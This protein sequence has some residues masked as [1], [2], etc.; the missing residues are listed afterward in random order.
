MSVSLEQWRASFSNWTFSQPLLL[1]SQRRGWQPSQRQQGLLYAPCNVTS[2]T[3]HPLP[4]PRQQTTQTWDRKEF[5]Q[6]HEVSKEESQS[7]A[8][9]TTV[10]VRAFW[11][12][13]LSCFSSQEKPVSMNTFKT[14]LVRQGRSHRVWFKHGGTIRGSIDAELEEIL[15][16]WVQLSEWQW[17]QDSP[18]EVT[19]R[20]QTEF[21]L[22]ND[23]R[24]MIWRTQAAEM[25]CESQ[26]R[27][28]PE[29][30]KA[31]KAEALTR[32]LWATFLSS[33]ICSANWD[34]V[35]IFIFI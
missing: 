6:V 12:S 34:E 32:P 3:A 16:A 17:G 5:A 14:K 29:R 25:F 30:W 13:P 31:V 26:R 2:A 24:P 1:K 22:A 35:F 8:V 23:S 11:S 19:D 33:A 7:G 4:W 20:A 21:Y 18:A 10:R 28:G 27:K 15:G 9:K